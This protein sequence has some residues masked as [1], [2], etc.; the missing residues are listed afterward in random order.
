MLPADITMSFVVGIFLALTARKE[1]RNIDSIFYNKYLCITLLWTGVIF[2][3]S[4]LLFL[5]D[6]TAWNLMYYTNPAE[7]NS[8]I[9]T[10]F[11][12]SLIV[13]MG[14]SGFML[15]HHLIR[16][17]DGKCYLPVIILI[18][19]IILFCAF[20]ILTLDRWF[21]HVSA[22]FEGWKGAPCIIDSQG[23]LMNLVIVGGIN[24]ISLAYI[25]HRF[26]TFT[27][28]A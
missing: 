22:E 25:L 21:F 17:K 4:T 16:K 18:A 28:N 10:I 6:W 8:Y 9:L 7:L 15:T 19:V 24:V 11:F 26:F 27:Q 12:P 2:M 14:A 5:Y 23:L 1:L 13:A 20:L 3:P